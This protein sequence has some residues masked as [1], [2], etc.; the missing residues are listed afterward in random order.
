VLLKDAAK[1]TSFAMSIALR[2]TERVVGN[3]GKTSS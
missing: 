2:R 1:G 3:V